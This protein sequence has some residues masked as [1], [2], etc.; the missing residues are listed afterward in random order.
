MQKSSIFI[1]GYGKMGQQIAHIL[2]EQ[3]TTFL[4]Y[5]EDIQNVEPAIARQ[6]VCVDFTT[7]DAFKKNYTFIAKHFK[8]AVVGTTGWEDIRQQVINCFQQEQTCLVYGNNFSIGVNIFYKLCAYATKCCQSFPQ[9][10]P[11]I[12]EMHHNQKLDAPSG[13]AKTIARSMSDAYNEVPISSVRCGSIPGIHQL[14][15]ES[16]QDRIVLKHEAFSRQGLA[17]G[18]IQAALWAE[19]LQ[20]VHSFESLF[21]QYFT[22]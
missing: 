17:C 15:F 14:G 3:K 22:L 21:D 8:A 13:T 2:E 9:Y 7:P 5:S 6:A 12:L 10:Q 1:S 20:G 18:A 19:Q 11:Y 4:G 16:A